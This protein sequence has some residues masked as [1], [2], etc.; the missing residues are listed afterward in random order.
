MNASCPDCGLIVTE[1]GAELEGKTVR[2]WT[3]PANYFDC[4]RCK[5]H[6]TNE[7]FWASYHD[8]QAHIWSQYQN[9]PAHVEE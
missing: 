6:Y 8:K 3:A 1:D 9:E 7:D 2:C 4:P 5:A